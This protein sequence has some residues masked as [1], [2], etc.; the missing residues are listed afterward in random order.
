MIL[1]I[2][3]G[4]SSIKFALFEVDNSPEKVC[5]GQ[6]TRVGTTGTRFTVNSDATSLPVTATTY[7][8]AIDFL[9][10]WLEQ[11]I[12]FS[13]VKAIG[14]RIVHGMQHTE[15]SLIDAE[16]LKDLKNI[17][18]YDPDHLPFEILLIEGFKK[19]H[20]EISQFACFD[21]DFHKDMPQVAKLLPIPRRFDRSGI[22]RY[23]FHGLSY[24]YLMQELEHLAGRQIADGRIII[25]HLGNGASLAAIKH[26]KSVDTSMGFTPD[27]GVPMSTRTGD[28]DPGVAW[29]MIKSEQLTPKQ[30]NHLISSESGLLGI[31]ETSGDMHDLLELEATDIRA[32]EAVSL[33]C[34]QVK[35][36]IGSF[37]AALGGLD[38]LIFTGGIGENAPSIRARICEGLGFLGVELNDERNQKNAHFISA[39]NGVSVRVM[40]TDEEMM[41]AKL[42]CDRMDLTTTQKQ[43]T[44][45]IHHA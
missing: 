43:N 15:P 4:S 29:F 30:F 27:S 17:G 18:A 31:S 10:E 39:A 42:V 23:G 11:N 44:K 32:A 26:G 6:L 1:T 8:G 7:K 33:F 19:N 21:T 12:T 24:H 25:T 35:K 36:W 37:A 3:G 9:V 20:A 14:H 5:Y 28:L 13:D 2:N 16:L 38:T 34:Y 40:H 22:H 41:I 45:D